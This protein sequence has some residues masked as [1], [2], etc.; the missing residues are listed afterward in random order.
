MIKNYL[1]SFFST[2]ISIICLSIVGIISIF[3]SRYVYNYDF[4]LSKQDAH[5]YILMAQDLNNFFYI[6]QQ[7][8]M[9]ILPS[10][11]NYILIEIFSIDY[12]LS[13]RI[14]SYL[15]FIILLNQIFF[16]F[17]KFEIKNYL[18]FSS[19][20][21][22]VFWN[23][24]ISYNIFNPFQLIDLFL[25][26]FVIYIIQFSIFFNRK[27]LLLFSFFALFTK[28]FLIVLVL[29]SYLK[30]IF[31]EKRKIHLDL[32][33]L[34]IIFSINYVFAGFLNQDAKISSFILEDISLYKT[35]YDEAYKCLLIEK[36][37]LFFLPFIIL[38][39]DT[40]FIKFLNKYKL[41]LV[42]AMIPILVSI[43]LY[44]LI[45]N[46][47]FRVYYQGFFVFILFTL[48]YITKSIENKNYLSLLYFFLPATFIIDFLYIFLNISQKGF[49]YYY[50]VVRFEYFS[51]YFLFSLLFIFI[52]FKLKSKIQWI[53]N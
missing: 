43:L 33:F 19:V 51:G 21:I 17:K 23:N 41:Y 50:N 5:S 1:Q 48:I 53:K 49:S 38:I 45:G 11:I 26:I 25:Y 37:I 52:F 18:A 4:E 7:E 24:S 46:N 13:F 8:A 27:G 28:E 31:L 15:F 34:I 10:F 20:L 9:R 3:I 12:F 2:K 39:L 32:L 29:L 30:C 42:Y 44:S 6:N 40:N 14:I 47:F 35:Y 36:K 16:F 22:L